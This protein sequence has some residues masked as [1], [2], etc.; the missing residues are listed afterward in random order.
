LDNSISRGGNITVEEV[1][2]LGGRRCGWGAWRGEIGG[3]RSAA[4]PNQYS[5]LLGDRQASCL[6]QLG[7]QVFDIVV[8]E[9]KPTL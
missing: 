6:D 7:L 2:F 3:S 9:S 8:I 1:S 5:S 4:P